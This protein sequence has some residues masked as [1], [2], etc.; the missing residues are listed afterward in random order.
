L[1]NVNDIALSDAKTVTW[2][3]NPTR[4]T[5]VRYASVGIGW[6]DDPTAKDF[7]QMSINKNHTNREREVH[8]AHW[9]VGTYRHSN[10]L[11][12]LLP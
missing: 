3:S 1:C 9:P 4:I 2:D 10:V 7:H 5:D 11:S 8:G 12:T 6:W